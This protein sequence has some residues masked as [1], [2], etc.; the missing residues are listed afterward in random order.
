MRALLEEENF[1][2]FV[3][4]TGSRGLHVTV[5][6]KPELDFD[7]VKPFARELATRLAAEAPQCFTT[8]IRKQER[9]NRIFVDYLR[10]EYAQTAVP[11]YAVRPKPGAPVAMPLVWDELDDPKL[12]SQRYNLRN[13]LKRLEKQGDVWAGLDRHAVSLKSRLR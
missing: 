12:D 3:M 4:T 2:A 7:D 5:P 11:P 1:P 9:G 10:N 6:I 13:V 8:E